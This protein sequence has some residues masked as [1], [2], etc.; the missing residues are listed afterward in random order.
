MH[1]ECFIIR[2]SWGTSWGDRGYAYVPYDYICNSNF[3]F[4]GQYAIM[5]LTDSDF[6][7][8]PDDGQ[9]YNYQGDG[10]ESVEFEEVEDDED[11]DDVPDD[12]GLLL[13]NLN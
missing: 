1:Q 6:T 2:N 12:S 9:D 3:N 8:D 11:D 4:L 7:P 13:R 5:G 10:D